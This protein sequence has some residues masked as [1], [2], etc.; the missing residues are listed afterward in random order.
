LAKI[1][2]GF[3]DVFFGPNEPEQ[4]Q[5]ESR[6]S[7]ARLVPNRPLLQSLRTIRRQVLG[8]NDI[9]EANDVRVPQRIARCPFMAR[10][11]QIYAAL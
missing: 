3:I 6:L 10:S 4:G 8:V 11:G 7:P 1:N 9:E 2:D 5:L